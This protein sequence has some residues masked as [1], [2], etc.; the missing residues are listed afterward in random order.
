MRAVVIDQYGG[1]DELKV[2]DV[3]MPTMGDKDLLVEVHAASVNPVDWKIRSGYL[4]EMLRYDFPLILGWD[5][6]GI[7]KETGPGVLNFKAGDKVFS[8]TDIRRNGTYAEYVAVQED[9][10]ALMPTD[11]TFTEAASIP[12]VGLT[13]W[14]S[15]IDF[16][17][18][19]GGD[20]VLIHA[21]AGGVG[22][23]AIQ[24]CK[25]RGAYVATTCS[26]FNVGFVKELGA[27]QVIDYTKSDFSLEIHN[28][29]IVF[30]TVGGDIYRK[31]FR[32]LKP[33]QGAIVSI[34]EQPNHELAEQ[35]G[36]RAG[37]VFMQPNGRQLAQ[38]ADLLRE[39]KIVPTVTRVLPLEEVKKAHELSESGHGRG[40][41]VLRIAKG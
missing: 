27:D 41:I 22:S 14:Q 2:R 32:V 20:K 31:S 36:V 7:V 9:Y 17:G 1:R 19:K 37:Y 3:P 23:F 8:R 15:L 18:V 26:T 40:K 10:A 29:D 25:S 33:Q 4:K 39:R 16:A 24:L 38:I 21:G 28:Y 6:A 12:L 5:M 13:S 11:L 30:D 34:L 35:H